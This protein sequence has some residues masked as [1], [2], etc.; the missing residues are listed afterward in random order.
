MQLQLPN[1]APKLAR[2]PVGGVPTRAD[3]DVR[4][5]VP[6][7]VAAVTVAR[8]TP[9]QSPPHTDDY[10][11]S[12]YVGS[13]GRT[14]TRIR[15][16]EHVLYSHLIAYIVFVTQSA[17]PRPAFSED[18]IVDGWSHGQCTFGGQHRSELRDLWR[19]SVP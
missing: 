4:I 9:F 17:A 13:R 14:H 7:V 1:P 6:P 16:Q 18:S 3:G 10:L 5:R 15:I 2:R 8:S 12:V 19:P 11:L